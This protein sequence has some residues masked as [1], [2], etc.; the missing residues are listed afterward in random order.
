MRI[1]CKVLVPLYSVCVDLMLVYGVNCLPHRMAHGEGGSC[2]PHPK[3]LWLLKEP[4]LDCSHCSTK[5]N[6]SRLTT[7]HKA[8]LSHFRRRGCAQRSHND[9][10]QNMSRALEEPLQS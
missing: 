4:C 10:K 9:M 8:A 7:H 6:T 1:N 2:M 3:V 5:S